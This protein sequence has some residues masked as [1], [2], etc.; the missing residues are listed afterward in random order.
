MVVVE[1]RPTVADIEFAGAKEFDKDILKKALSQIGLAD[2]RP[3]DK[4]LIDRAEQELKRQYINR[5]MYAVEVVT[6]VT[7][8]ERNRVNVTFSVI[9]GEPAR[10]SDIRI[11]GN[12]AFSSPRCVACLI[13]TRAGGSP[14]T[15]NLDRYART[16][17]NA[18]LEALRSYYLARGYWSSRSSPPRWRFLRTSKTLPSP[19]NVNRRRPVCG[20][21]RSIWR[22]ISWARK[23]NSGRWLWFRLACPQRR[24]GGFDHRHLTTIS[25][26][27]ATRSRVEQRTNIDKHHQ[28]GRSDVAG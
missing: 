13:W 12:K 16:K 10:I 1:E 26:T 3:L 6:T 2:G 21:Q 22:A 14:G 11:V 7:P 18:D 23:K 27:L 9:E 17:L 19:S 8:V 4:A 5:S 15:P 28:P 20:F 25:E 24:P